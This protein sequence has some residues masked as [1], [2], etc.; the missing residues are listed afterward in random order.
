MDSHATTPDDRAWYIAE[1]WQQ[2]DG[3][4]RANALR[5]SAIGAFYVLH[6][7]NYASSQGKLPAWGVL[8]LSDAGP[9]DRRFHLLVSMLALSWASAAAVVY[10]CLRNRIFPRWISLAA[11][12][13]DLVMLTSVLC[14]SNGP[15]SPLV[16]G[17]FLVI[18]LAGLRFNL[19]LVRATTVGAALGYLVV[20]GA[21]RWPATFGLTPKLDLHVLRY[22]QLA[23]LVALVM[24][25]VFVGQIV[26]RT[27]LLAVEYAA[28]LDGPSV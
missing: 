3:E 20:L 28:R 16:A 24:C 5:L 21:A 8:Q 1:R 14:I 23:T 15:K 26:R 2:F 10:L 27:R 17:Y 6:L 22:H 19:P 25:G 12:A 9:V 13:V 18:A 4:L 11:T 7:W